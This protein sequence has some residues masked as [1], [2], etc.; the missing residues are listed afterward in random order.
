MDTVD[1]SAEQPDGMGSFGADVLET[2][3]VVRHLRWPGHLT[4]SLQPQHQQVQHQAIVLDD[5]RGKLQPTDD[6]VTVCVIHVL[7]ERRYIE[8]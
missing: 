8:I 7:R 6:A 1:I 3:E 4:G 5:E 2:E